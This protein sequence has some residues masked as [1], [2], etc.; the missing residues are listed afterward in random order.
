MCIGTVLL[1]VLLLVAC[2]QEGSL[3]KEE[4]DAIE[5][6]VGA[7]VT[8]IY[9]EV[10]VW[11]SSYLADVGKNDFN[12]RFLTKGFRQLYDKA[13]SIGQEKNEVPEGQDYDHWIQAQDWGAF[14]AVID[15]INVL[16]RDTAVVFLAL[17]NNHGA[18]TPFALMM[19]KE[20]P[21]CHASDGV[22]LI[23]DFIGCDAAGHFYASSERA[24][25]EKYIREN[26]PSDKNDILERQVKARVLE[27]YGEIIAACQAAK[28]KGKVQNLYEFN[29]DRFLTKDYCQWY[30]RVDSIDHGKDIGEMFFFDAEHWGPSLDQ[31]GIREAKVLRIRIINEPPRIPA[32]QADVMLRLT[33]ETYYLHKDT[34]VTHSDVHL[35]MA[36]ERGNWYIDD[37][38]SGYL[39]YSEKD[40]MKAYVHHEWLQGVWDY[41][42]GEGEVASH[43]IVRGDTLIYPKRCDPIEWNTYIFRLAGDTL[44]LSDTKSADDWKMKFSFTDGKL[45]TTEVWPDGAG[46]GKSEAQEFVSVKRKGA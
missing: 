6:E 36:Y 10:C 43:Y 21:G 16:T 19:V 34:L 29:T 37:F 4:R 3:T 39:P 30:A 42:P 45:R 11:Y 22:W 40:M 20:K 46:K 7:R 1:S 32:L 26:T 9:D 5:M 38:L 17:A 25:M 15:S 12:A 28:A 41:E 14:E 44:F 8:D 27:L 13:A 35:R 2:R 23:D 18:Y 33:C 31:D 24:T